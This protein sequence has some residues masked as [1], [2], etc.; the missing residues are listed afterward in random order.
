MLRDEITGSLSL[1]TLSSHMGGIM[2]AKK[3][4]NFLRFC[5]LSTIVLTFTASELRRARM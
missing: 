3:H 1:F 5:Y 2:R 4:T